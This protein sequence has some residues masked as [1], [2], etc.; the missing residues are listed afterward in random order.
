MYDD[1]SKLQEEVNQ[2]NWEIEDIREKHQRLPTTAPI[3]HITP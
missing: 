1:N 2:L 3:N